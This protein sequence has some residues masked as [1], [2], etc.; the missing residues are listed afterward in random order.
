MPKEEKVRKKKKRRKK[1]YLLKFIMVIVLCTGLYFFFTSSLFD[2][3]KIIVENNKYYTSEQI[4]GIA[5]A[6]PGKNLFKSSTS[7]MKERLLKDPYLKSVKVKRKLPDT[8]KIIVEERK[9]YAAIPY[10]EGFV[11]IDQEGLVLRKVKAEPKLTLLLGM[12]VKD[13]TAGKALKV[14]E[15][16]VL[17]D[18]LSMLKKMEAKELYFKKIDISHV[19]IKAYIYDHLTCEGTPE[20]ILKNLE[21][22]QEV[23]YDLYSKG[24]KRGVI[25]VGTEGYF[26]FSPL[27]E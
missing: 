14:E 1:H 16:S 6:K 23:L 15:N 13:T 8:I 24:I 17:T 3:Q 10:G 25:K 20:N 5:K 18:T 27:E 26:S 22:I 21:P 4:I 7:D 9:E 19:V 11:I 2:I 12:T